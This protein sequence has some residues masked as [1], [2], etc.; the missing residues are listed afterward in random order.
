MALNRAVFSSLSAGGFTVF[1][2]TP[3][4]T[5]FRISVQNHTPFIY[6]RVTFLLVL[7]ALSLL[8]LPPPLAYYSHFP[9]CLWGN[10]HCSIPLEK[11]FKEN[12]LMMKKPSLPGAW[13]REQHMCMNHYHLLHQPSS[14]QMSKGD[15]TSTKDPLWHTLTAWLPPTGLH[16]CWSRKSLLL[17]FIPHPLTVTARIYALKFKTEGLCSEWQASIEAMSFN[18]TEVLCISAFLASGVPMALLLLL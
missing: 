10:L 8:P 4:Y 7:C 16:H 12:E 14:F 15:V 13:T 18:E 2:I 1:R 9:N 17:S 5:P 11:V 6:Q 3:Q